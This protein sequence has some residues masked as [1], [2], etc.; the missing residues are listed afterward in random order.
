MLFEDAGEPNIKKAVSA[1][2]IVRESEAIPSELAVKIARLLSQA[3]VVC[4]LGFGYQKA[5]V[6]R[7]N[8]ESFKG[9]RLFGSA[10]GLL[11]AERRR[12]EALFEQSIVLGGVESDCLEYLRSTHV[13][14]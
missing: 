8:F 2:E 5:N 14:E 11:P 3:E 1:I 7:L 10:H 13:F 12:A 6:D 9:R 4:F